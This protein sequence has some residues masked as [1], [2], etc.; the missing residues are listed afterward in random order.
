MPTDKFTIYFGTFSTSFRTSEPEA[1]TI[2]GN[3]SRQD[4]RFKQPNKPDSTR[5]EQ[6][7]CRFQSDRSLRNQFWHFP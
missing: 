2:L 1:S 6:Q 5:K 4:K 7:R 3:L